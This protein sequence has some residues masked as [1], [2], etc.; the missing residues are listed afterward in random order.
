MKLGEETE[1]VGFA[2]RL[3]GPIDASSVDVFCYIPNPVPLVEGSH[4]NTP[5]EVLSLV[6]SL[7]RTVKK[8]AENGAGGRI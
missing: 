4:D 6:L 2:R 7:A 3:R 5:C 8:S 1:G